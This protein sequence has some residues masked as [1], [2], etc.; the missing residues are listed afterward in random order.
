M[1]KNPVEEAIERL[2][3]Q[4]EDVAAVCRVSR[5]AVD[6]W[7]KLGYVPRTR[8]AVVLSWATGISVTRLAGLD[9]SGRPTGTTAVAEIA[10]SGAAAATVASAAVAGPMAAESRGQVVTL[11]DGPTR[12]R[13]VRSGDARSDSGARHAAPERAHAALRLA[14]AVAA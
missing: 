3:G 1:V 2:G 10:A 9:E 7:L 8:Y 5:T 14:G 11:S 6:Q 4:R 12:K 13:K